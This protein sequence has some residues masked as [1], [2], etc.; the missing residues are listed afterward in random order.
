M[1]LRQS[2]GVRPNPCRG[3]FIGMMSSGSN[4]AEGPRGQ[5]EPAM[6]YE[7]FDPEVLD[8]AVL[9]ELFNDDDEDVEQPVPD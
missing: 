1:T 4:P 7:D 2:S 9:E 8:D 6:G 5:E 3:R